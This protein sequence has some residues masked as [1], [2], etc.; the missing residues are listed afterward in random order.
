MAGGFTF[1]NSFKLKID[2]IKSRRE[3]KNNIV[4]ILLNLYQENGD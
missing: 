3:E 1:S 2:F 4:Q